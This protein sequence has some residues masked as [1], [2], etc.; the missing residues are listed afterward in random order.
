MVQWLKKGQINK[1]MLSELMQH[2]Y[3]KKEPPK[4][5][6]RED[7]GVHFSKEILARYRNENVSDV[8]ILATVTY[9]TAK[10]IGDSYKRWILPETPLDLVIVGGGGSYNN[11]LL[12]YIKKKNWK[13]LV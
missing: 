1:H 8:D 3:I 12:K 13:V 7:F 5:T 11:T 10:S 6:G 9:F 4:T 2:P